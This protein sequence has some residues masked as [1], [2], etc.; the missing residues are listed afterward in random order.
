MS[1]TQTPAEQRDSRTLRR[2]FTVGIVLVMLWAVWLMLKPMR[3]PIAWAAILAFLLYPLQQRLTLALRGPPFRG[4]RHPHGAH[5]DRH[6]R[7]ADADRHR[8][9]AAGR[10][11]R[12]STAAEPGFLRRVA[13][14]RSGAASA[15]GAACGLG[16]SPLRPATWRIC[17]AYLQIQRPGMGR[18]A[19]QVQRHAVPEHGGR[20]AEL[21]P[22]AVH[23]VLH[24]A[25]WLAVVRP[26]RRTAAT[27]TEHSARRCSPAWA[28]CCAPWSMAADSR[29]WCRAH[30]SPSASPSRGFRAPS[31][32]ACWPACWHCCHSAARAGV[33]ARRALPACHRQLW[34]GHLHAGLGRRG[35]HFGQL[36]PPDHHL[37][38]HA[39]A[40]AAGVPRRHRRRGRIRA[41]SASSSGR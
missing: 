34:L 17:R 6:L 20:G 33:G 3:M 24:A 40:H 4:R 1:D 32:S 35:V 41:A 38:L 7:A 5:A 29:R 37:A 13:L 26:R 9:R 8:L 15:H 10:R 28:R 16:L 27:G 14:A 19:G 22:D 25:R 12:R 39:G 36:H 31:C 11:H 18:H 23:P 2:W 21:L 30:W